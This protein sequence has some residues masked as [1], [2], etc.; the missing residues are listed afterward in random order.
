VRSFRHAIA[1]DERRS[2]FNANLWQKQILEESVPR[3][4]IKRKNTWYELNRE[5]SYEYGRGE[6]DVLEVYFAGT[7]ADVG[8]GEDK[9]DRVHSL[10]NISLRWMIR[11]IAQSQCGILL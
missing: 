11:E 4:S 3:G 5:D 10:S 7:H 9:D 1:L 6:T 2:K 8:G